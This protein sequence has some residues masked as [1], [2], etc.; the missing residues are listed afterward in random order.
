MK[1]L[2]KGA[3]D[4][5]KDILG[6]ELHDGDVCVGKGTGRDV[7]RM[8][9]GV[10]SG[11]S[12]AFR[13]GQK[14]SMGD[15]FLV[16][17]P[18]KEELEIKQDIEKSLSEIESKRKEKESMPTISLSKLQIGGVYKCNN[19]QTYIY[20]GKRKV[21]LEDYCSSRD[22]VA[23][24][25]CFVYTNS[26]WSDDKIKED[27][28]NVNIYHGT[29]NIDVLKGNKKLTEFIRCIELIFPMVNE[30]KSDGY[31]GYRSEYH[32]KLLIE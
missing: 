11:K 29:H 5:S 16:V 12:I 10:W 30:V 31:N 32:F 25:H 1:Y 22:D 13:G 15:V 19:G 7:A 9:V 17:N 6:R 28:L 23:E 2:S 4:L 24:G 8:N 21:T 18:S 27:I 26:E 3:H 14:R 20:L